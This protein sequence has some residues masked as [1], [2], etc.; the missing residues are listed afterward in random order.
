MLAVESD[1][2]VKTAQTVDAVKNS[3]KL[4]SESSVM[5]VAS[6]ATDSYQ[7]SLQI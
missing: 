4:V 7:V 6:L 5:L 2:A 1:S 3:L